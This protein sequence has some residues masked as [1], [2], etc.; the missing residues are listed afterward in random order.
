L[1]WYRSSFVLTRRDL[2]DERPWAID[3]GRLRKGFLWVNGQC[4]GRYW[5]CPAIEASYAR[6]TNHPHLINTGHGQP[7]QQLYHVP[8]DWLR[9]GENVVVVLAEQGAAVEGLRLLRR[10]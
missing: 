6:Y 8:P 2:A 4:L 1:R 10:R 7:T 9:E 3:V 5:K